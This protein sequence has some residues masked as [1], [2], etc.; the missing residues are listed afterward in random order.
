MKSPQNPSRRNRNIGT[1]KQGHGADNRLVI[2]EG[3]WRDERRFPERL[4]NPREYSFE[5]YDEERIALVEQPAEG[6]SYGCTVSDIEH[7]LRLVPEEDVSGLT[8]FLFRNPTRKQRILSSVWGRFLYFA[9]P[10]HFAG[11]A[12]CFESQSLESLIWSKSLN[13]EEQRNLQRLRQDGHEVEVGRRNIEIKMSSASFRATTLFRT[14]LHEIGHYVDWM[15]NVIDFEG[16]EEEVEAA[17]RAFY[18][19]PSSMK[20]DFAHRYASEALEKLKSEGKAPFDIRWNSDSMESSGIQ[21]KWFVGGG[22]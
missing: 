6:Y 9:T 13:P 2:P 8:V 12:I 20:E 5:V 16:T 21:R 10:G 17:S 22:A 15:T 1:A 4:V 11:S 7:L 14:A 19:K 3:A 18:S